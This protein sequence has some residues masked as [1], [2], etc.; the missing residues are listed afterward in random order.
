MVVC[1][2]TETQIRKCHERLER[3][4]IDLLEP[5]GRSERRHWGA[6]YVRGYHKSTAPVSVSGPGE[7]PL[8]AATAPRHRWKG[9]PQR[10]QQRLGVNPG[11][12][13]AAAAR[14]SLF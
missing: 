6:V 2:M 13:T 14:Y 4:L 3:F 8:G 12:E 5:V 9:G 1:D 11:L 7:R 10:N